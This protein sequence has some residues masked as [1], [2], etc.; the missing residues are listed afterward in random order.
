MKKNG[1]T[2]V[3]LLAVIVILAVIMIIAIP[4]VLDTV[5]VSRKKSFSSYARKAVLATETANSEE[6]MMQRITGRGIYTYSVKEDLGLPTTGSYEGYVVVDNCT[7]S[8]KQ[9]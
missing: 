1:F 7:Q 8:E 5:T 3:E 2:L 6:E 9:Y 4:S